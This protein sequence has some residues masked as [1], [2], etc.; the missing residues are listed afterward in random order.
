MSIEERKNFKTVLLF[1]KKNSICILLILS[2]SSSVLFMLWNQRCT[3]KNV[4][5][6]E[7]MQFFRKDT[8]SHLNH[9]LISGIWSFKSASLA[10]VP[11]L[12]YMSENT[13]SLIVKRECHFLLWNSNDILWSDDYISQQYGWKNLWCNACIKSGV[14]Y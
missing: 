4:M 2:I 10:H 7:Y 13:I 1:N 5:W 11:A 6:Y 3:F 14:N 12:N 9:I 8:W